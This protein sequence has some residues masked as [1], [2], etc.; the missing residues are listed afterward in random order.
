MSSYLLDITLGDTSQGRRGMPSARK[1]RSMKAKSKI[2]PFK[3]ER[4]FW[5][6]HD[7]AQH[8]G[9]RGRLQGTG[10]RAKT[11]PRFDERA[12]AGTRR[13]G[14][15]I[16]GANGARESP[17][18]VTLARRFGNRDASGAV[19]V[20]GRSTPVAF[21]QKGRSRGGRSR[22]YR[23][24]AIKNQRRRRSLCPLPHPRIIRAFVPKPP[25]TD[26]KR[27]RHAWRQ[28]SSPRASRYSPPHSFQPSR[29]RW[30][31]RIS[32]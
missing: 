12:V 17:A 14:A 16:V 28:A 8:S 29:P 15:G 1:D 11:H 10:Q 24:C 22:D 4:A 13:G 9:G 32:S 3:S 2:P 21:R 5:E 26:G 19:R 25:L 30:S 20:A 27:W 18:S 23:P 7:S 6:A 31:I